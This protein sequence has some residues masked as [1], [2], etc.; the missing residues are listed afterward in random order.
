MRT[1]VSDQE[2]TLY[3][4]GQFLHGIKKDYPSVLGFAVWAAGSFDPSYVLSITPTNGVD[5]QLFDIAVKPNLP[6]H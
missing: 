4:L 1:L 2:L 3:S 5:N 6:G